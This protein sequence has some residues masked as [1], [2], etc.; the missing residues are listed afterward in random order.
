MR[1]GW[2]CNECET[3]SVKRTTENE[4]VSKEALSAVR[5]TDYDLPARRPSPDASGLGY[6]HSS[7]IAD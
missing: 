2:D 1:R 7:A 5:F 3:E 4:Q 6:F